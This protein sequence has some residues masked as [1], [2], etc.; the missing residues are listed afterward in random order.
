MK[1]VKLLAALS[2]VIFVS[3]NAAAQRS[4][5]SGTSPL[6]A[7]GVYNCGVVSMH[8]CATQSCNTRNAS[9]GME[10]SIDMENRTA[11]IRRGQSCRDSR[12]FVVV[13]SKNNL[14][15]IFAQDSM[16]FVLRPNGDLV[17]ADVA[18]GQIINFYARCAR[19]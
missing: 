14:N 18:R 6:P 4:G 10:L 19:G 3:A 7:T 9:R 8:R 11:C 16:V 17:G 13:P 2:A 1:L 12:R 15:L 5:P